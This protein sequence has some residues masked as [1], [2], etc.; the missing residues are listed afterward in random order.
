MAW[1]FRE[2]TVYISFQ[3][4]KWWLQ[5]IIISISSWVIMIFYFFFINWLSMHIQMSISASYARS[6]HAIT[7][8]SGVISRC[9]ACTI[10]YYRILF[11]SCCSSSA[12]YTTTFLRMCLTIYSH[13]YVAYMRTYPAPETPWKWRP[14]KNLYISRVFLDIRK[15]KRSIPGRW[16]R[17]IGPST[18]TD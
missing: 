13:I 14:I 4:C 3:C 16:P 12:H 2:H 7:P 18:W 10:N 15:M 6:E 11:D 17:W 8:S 5:L 9:H 1:I